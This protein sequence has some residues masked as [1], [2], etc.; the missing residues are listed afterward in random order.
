LNTKPQ[1]ATDKTLS[2]NQQK[3][4]VQNLVHILTICPELKQIIS[5]WPDLPE[6]IKQ[7]IT[8]LV[9]KAGK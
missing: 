4:E 7:T 6:H 1:P 9:E 8:T 5:A 2:E 3:Q